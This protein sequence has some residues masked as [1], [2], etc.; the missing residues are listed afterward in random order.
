M[1][2]DSDVQGADARLAVQ[3]YKKSVKQEDAS[4]EAGRPIFKE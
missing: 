4:N 1:A 3:F 2:I